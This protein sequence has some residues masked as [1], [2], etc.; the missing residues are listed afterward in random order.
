MPISFA[1]SGG[2]SRG[3]FQ[4]GVLRY[5]YD[6]GFRPDLI[7]STS[8]GSI[9]ALKLAEGEDASNPARGLQGLERTWLS[10]RQDGDMWETEEWYRELEARVDGFVQSVGTSDF[11]PEWALSFVFLVV[12]ASAIQQQV[13]SLIAEANRLARR[14]TS[15][16]NLDPI[17]RRMGDPANL[18]WS[19]IQTSRIRLRLT[20]VSLDTGDVRYVTERGTLLDAQL[21]P[22]RSLVLSLAPECEEIQRTITALELE[23][24]RLEALNEQELPDSHPV[25]VRLGE[26][27]NELAECMERNPPLPVPRRAD[28]LRAALASASI[29]VFFPPVEL[30]GEVFCD[31]GVR[32]WLPVDAALRAP[33]V[34]GQGSYTADIVFAIAASASGVAVAEKFAP[35]GGGGPLPSFRGANLIDIVA[36]TV[37]LAV[38]EVSLN[39]VEPRGMGWPDNVVVIQSQLPEF[40][41]DIRTVDPG[42]IRIRMAYGYMRAD[43]VLRAKGGESPSLDTL[44]RATRD[45]RSTA[46]TYSE[47]RWTN[48]IIR[49]R[50]AIWRL[51]RD[52]IET[53]VFALSSVLPQ[54]QEMKAE[55][56]TLVGR[57]R[58][59]GFAV[60]ADADSWARDWEA[61]SIT[62]SIEWLDVTL[63]ALAV[64]VTPASI[65]LGQ[66]VLLTVTVR[67]SDG[68]PVPGATVTILNYSGSSA[69]VIEVTLTTDSAGVASDV[70]TF[71]QSREF[72][73]DAGSWVLGERPTGTVAAEGFGSVQF[74]LVFRT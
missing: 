7:S 33:D 34:D 64:T 35:F 68:R 45:Y 57:R 42:L 52:A 38:E 30:G 23:Q 71:H 37:G 61:H 47:S 11:L 2:G 3:D 24:E 32:E 58:A 49:R 17:F 6:R 65:Q 27:G 67:R 28:A 9:N 73:A 44:V 16:Y 51:E 26:L 22:V 12:S 29:P 53:G 50:L 74:P 60:P 40:D 20:V 66:P 59:A 39:E 48:E 46:D 72:D 54:L 43:D 8:V 21:R 1:L 69:E 56:A 14:A 15:F 70:L 25:R 19:F 36:R 10:L 63:P 18:T 55:V 62:P 41:H 4:I 5:L 13:Q 31:G